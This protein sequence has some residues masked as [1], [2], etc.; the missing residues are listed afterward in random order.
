MKPVEETRLE[1]LRELVAEFGSLAALNRATGKRDTDSTYSQILNG[2]ISSTSGRPKLMG[3]QM[4]RQI[5]TA[6]GKPNGWMDT[7]P[8]AL[9]AW[10]FS[11]VSLSDVALL[12]EP[13]RRDLE[14]TIK[15]F[16]AGCLAGRRG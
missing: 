1:R 13:D 11:S 12:S 7:S 5:E 4:A 15:R 16:V 3:S 2:S 9:G 10:P 6:V 8:E 14:T